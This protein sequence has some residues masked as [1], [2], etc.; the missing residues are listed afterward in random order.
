MEATNQPQDLD[1]AII[2]RRSARFHKNQPALKQKEASLKLILNN[3]N[4]DK[5]V[6]LLEVAQEND[7]FSGSDLKEICQD[8]VLLCVR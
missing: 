1:S 3:E 6:D 5:C 2:R 7:G 4:V 8:A